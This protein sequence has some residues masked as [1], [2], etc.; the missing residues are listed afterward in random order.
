MS[1]TRRKRRGNELRAASVRAALAAG[2]GAGVLAAVGGPRPTGIAAWDVALVVAATTAAAWASA[3]TP[4][5]A[6]IVA[7][8]C[9][10]IAAPTWWGVTLALALAGGAAAIG[11]RRVSWGWARGAIIAAVAAAGAHAGN[12]WAIGVTA[13][14]VGGAVTVAAVAGVRRRPS[15]VRRRAWMV[16]GVVG[17]AAGAAVLVAVLGVLSARGDLREGERLARLG[18][19]QAQ[20]GDT[21]GARASLLD[22]ASA[23]ERASSTLDAAWMLPGRTVPVLAQH[24]RALTDLSAAAGPA[25]GDAAAALDEVDTSRL[26]MVDGAFDLAGITALDQPFARLSAAVRSLATT[27]DA[28]DRGWLVG[29][30]QARLD[31][32]GDE[33]ARNQRLLDNASRAVALAPDL[34]GASGPRHYFVAFMTPAEARGLGGFM[35]NWAEITVDGGRI[36]MT[37]FGTDEVL[38]RGGDDPDGRV[39]T[40]PAEFLQHYGQFGFVGADG[41][42]SMVPWKNITMPADFPMVAE[43]IAGLYPQSGGRPLDGVFAVDIAGIAALMKL[44]GP[45]RVEGLNRPLNANTVEDFLLRDQYLLERDERADMLDA[46][47]RTVV[48][49]LLTTT[50]PEPTELARTLGPLVPARHLM[51]WSPLADEEALFTALGLDGAVTTWLGTAAGQ[52]VASPGAVVVARNNAAAN[53][54]DVYVPMEVTADATGATVDLANI[55]DIATLPDYVD[56]NPLGLPEGTARTRVTVY[57]TVPVAGFTLDGTTLPVS[58]GEEAGAFAYTFVLDLAPGATATIR[59]E[60]AP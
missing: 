30:L 47:A 10:A 51:A 24:Q 31:G 55:A 1:T 48:D 5:W 18:L 43:A 26:E 27:T 28:I 13:L 59:L 3:S 52:A 29:P 7:P 39:I 36:W 45:V 11:I 25:I 50:L 33:L 57:T 8:G 35:G 41:T 42:T 46:I 16:L 19:A 58:S 54:L 22:A 44:T 60:W 38:N 4:W 17:G 49:A 21:E 12:R 56:G 20:R 23:F 34:L 9:L 6:L 2:L 53:K 40:G 14:L 32:V 37:A 15:F